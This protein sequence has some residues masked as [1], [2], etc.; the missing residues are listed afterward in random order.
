MHVIQ[1]FA[2]STVICSTHFSEQP[3]VAE[4]C[5]LSALEDE[6]FANKF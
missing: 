3:K 4:L 1:I 2:Q 5:V 6:A